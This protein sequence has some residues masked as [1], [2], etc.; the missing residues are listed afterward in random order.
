MLDDPS[1]NFESADFL[2]RHLFGVCAHD[3]MNFVGGAIGLLE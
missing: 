3:Q 1:R 2:L